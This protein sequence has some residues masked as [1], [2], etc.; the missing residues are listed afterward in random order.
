DWLARHDPRK[1][2]VGVLFYRAHWMSGNLDFV[3][4][5]VQAIETRGGNALPVFTSSLKDLTTDTDKPTADWPAAFQYFW[6][7]GRSLVDAIVTTMSFS[8]GD[9]KADGPTM[10]GWSVGAL[11]M[12]DVP[13]LQAI[14]CGSAR[15]QW[16][17][18]A[19]GLTPLDTAMNV[20][21]PEFDGR[22][23]TVPV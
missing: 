3:N 11:A 23:I 8:M 20:A 1:P 6:H 4:A 17:A 21:L 12:L 15:W 18:S 2:T 13:V 5:F 19:R 22:I 16:E 14:T 9:V 10:A 7:D